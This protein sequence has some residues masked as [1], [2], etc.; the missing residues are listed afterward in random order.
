MAQDHVSYLAVDHIPVI[1]VLG[2]WVAIGS[3]DGERRGSLV[4]MG[5]SRGRDGG[6]RVLWRRA[7]GLRAG[8]APGS[9]PACL[10]SRCSGSPGRQRGVA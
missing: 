4:L 6:V 3:R 1:A 8:P 7:G 5:V 9:R 10:L 2:A